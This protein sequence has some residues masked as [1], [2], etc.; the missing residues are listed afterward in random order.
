[1]VIETYRDLAARV[2]RRPPRLGRT[3]LVA[4]DGPSAAGKT[5][6]AARLAAALPGTP[7]VHSDDLLDG[8]ADQFT[9]WPRLEEW[10]LRPLAA[11]Q[12]GRYRRYDWRRGTFSP[13]WIEVPPAPVVILE[14]STVARE[15][16]R[17]RL[18]FAVFVDAPRQIREARSLARDGTAMQA[19]LA[20]WRER[21]ERHFRDEATAAHVDLVVAGAP[22]VSYDPD[23]EYVRIDL[24]S[25][26]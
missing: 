4:V 7:V 15:A 3:R 11:G 26:S 19:Q 6:F 5:F 1:M 16:A 22:D 18:S 10:V 21:E 25:P 24:R 9:F 13:E 23:V 12:P 2:R 14:G 17:A 20:H 8:W